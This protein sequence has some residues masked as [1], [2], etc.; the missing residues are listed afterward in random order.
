MIGDEARGQAL[1]RPRARCPARV[2]ACVGG[3]SNA[4]GI[5]TAFLDDAEVELIGVE[6]GRGGARSGRHGASLGA[7]RDRRPARRA[8][9]GPRRRG[10]ADP[11]GALDLGRAR[12][13]RRRPRA[14]LP[15]RQRAG[16]L[17]GGHRRARRCGPSASSPGSRGSSPRSSP[18]TRSPGCSTNPAA[19]G[20]STSS[21]SPAAATRTSPRR[22]R[23]SSGS[24]AEAT[25]PRADRGRL[26]G[27]RATRAGRR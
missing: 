13:P 20:G 18:P 5:F 1:E 4:I 17:R 22:S 10:R 21:A 12:L 19:S 15:A 7:G 3:G 26:R 11:R 25:G 9:L 27:G 2:I 14:R 6:A 16:P 8:L 24:M 23:R